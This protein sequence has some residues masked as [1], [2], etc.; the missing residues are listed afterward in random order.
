[1]PELI[2]VTPGSAE[3][4]AARREGI[5]ATDIPVITGLVT[6]NSAYR[7]YHEKLGIIEP[8]PQ[9][10]LM[11][12]GKALEEHVFAAW[13]GVADPPCTMDGGLYRSSERP[14]QMATFD[15]LAVTVTDGDLEPVEVKTCGFWDGWGDDG[16][17]GMP[18]HVRA[19]LL[20]Q[21]DVWGAARGHVACMSRLSGELRS[22][23]IEHSGECAWKVVNPASSLTPGACQTCADIEQLRMAGNVFMKRLQRDLPPPSVDGSAA[24]LAALKA[25]YTPAPEKIAVIDPGLWRAYDAYC[26]DVTRYAAKRAEGQALIREMAGDCGALEVGGQIVARFDKRGALRRIKAKEDD[27][28]E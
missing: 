10:D 1:M 3:W 22:Y 26:D 7:L 14:W 13:C 12:L 19:Q 23:V 8:L 6:W 24:T 15:R 17:D 25:R 4:L 28:G 5:T 27:N 9:T 18:V 11:A 2:D 16:T 20:W 21:M